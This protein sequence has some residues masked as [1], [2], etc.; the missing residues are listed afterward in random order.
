MIVLNHDV[1]GE[2]DLTY[3]SVRNQSLTNAVY[4]LGNWVAYAWDGGP[5]I[6]RS[7]A[8]RN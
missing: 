2:N 3:H 8:G 1:G 6:W 7:E 4:R 5:T